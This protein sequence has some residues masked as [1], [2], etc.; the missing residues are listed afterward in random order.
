M[1]HAAILMTLLFVSYAHGFVFFTSQKRNMTWNEVL[2][3][4]SI[5]WSVSSDA[6][7]ICQELMRVA[8]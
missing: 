3:K 8:A 2:T 1:R 7:A 4:H 6:P 5:R